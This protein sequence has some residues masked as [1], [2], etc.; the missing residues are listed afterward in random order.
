MTDLLPLDGGTGGDRALLGGKAAGIDRFVALGAP[1]PPAF[2]VT[3]EVCRQYYRESRRVPAQVWARLPDLVRGLERA[4]GRAF[5]RGPRPLLLSVRSGAAVSMPGMMDTVLNVGLTPEIEPALGPHGADTH[6]RFTGQ[7]EEVVGGRP[8]A[9]PWDQLRA[10]ITAVL[11]SW[12]SPRAVAYRTR[13]GL[14][15][16]AGTAVTVQAMVFGNRDGRSGTGVVFS[17]D[18]VGGGAEVYGEWLPGGQGEELVAGRADARPLGDLH[19]VLPG[20]YRELREWVRVLERDGR[21]VQDVEFTVE[22]GTLWL[23]QSRV[24][25]RSPEAAVRHAVAMARE[26]LISREEALARVEH[27]GA[28]LRPVIEPG[29]AAAGTVLAR[30]KPA[31]PGVGIGVVV[32]DTVAAQ[33]DVVLA[34]RT[35]DPRDV[36]VMAVAQAVVT[37][38]GGSTSHAAVV[39]RELGVPCVVGCGSG[40]LT[41]LDGQL[42]TVDGS[43]GLV[44]AGALPTVRGGIG[45]EAD[46]AV[47]AEW[48]RA[49]PDLPG[50]RRFLGSAAIP[51]GD[52]SGSARTAPENVR[53]ADLS[54]TT[55]AL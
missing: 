20:A 15:H 33:G 12:M 31:G 9:D 47:L 21:D 28:L 19:A 34:R 23:L 16:E 37:E 41:A 1:T 29:A 4:T 52:S 2:V 25:K 14:G 48:A 6:R 44:Y 11:E 54:N 26:G 30:G 18:P 55:D 27:V 8:P 13:Q 38:L 40:A 46:L 7:F 45:V 42:V 32:G 35:T 39:C 43:S 53:C 24:A 10:A 36:P 51:S 5:G 22:S 49:A 50:A 3:T 17:R